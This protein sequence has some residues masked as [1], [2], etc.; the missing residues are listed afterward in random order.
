MQRQRKVDVDKMSESQ[1]RNAEEAIGRKT[2]EITDKAVE[3]ANKYL[4]VY[5]LECRMAIEIFKQGEMPKKLGIHIE[6][7][8]SNAEA[9]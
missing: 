2:R 7:G 4:N 8:A 1:L 6:E 9:R 5:G 3:E